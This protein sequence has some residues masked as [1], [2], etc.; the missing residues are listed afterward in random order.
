MDGGLWPFIPAVVWFVS[1][2][3]GWDIVY[4][5]WVVAEGGGSTIAR[6]VSTL[7]SGGY[8]ESAFRPR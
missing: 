5:G 4:N 1:V 2:R 3:K 8:E 7:E 6:A